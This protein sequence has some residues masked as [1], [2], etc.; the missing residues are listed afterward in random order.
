MQYEDQIYVLKF[1]GIALKI[2][3]F[4]TMAVA[5]IVQPRHQKA[6]LMKE[7]HFEFSL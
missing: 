4:K 6:P 3:W 1:R 5:W 2:S 7:L